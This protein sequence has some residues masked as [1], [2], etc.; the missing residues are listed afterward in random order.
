MSTTTGLPANIDDELLARAAALS[1]DFTSRAAQ[2]DRDASFPFENFDA[3]RDAGLL[4]LTI[5]IEFGGLSASLTTVC[6]V[7]EAIGGGDPSTALVLSMHYLGHATL[8]RERRWDPDIY[9]RMCHESVQG[10]ALLAPLRVEP[11]LGTPARGGLPETVATRCTDGWH[12]TGHKIYATGSP[13]VRYF[14]TWGRTADDPP[15]LGRFLVPRDAPGMRVVETWDH[16]GM[17]ASG[18]HD[19]LFEDALLPLEYAVDLR[20]PAAWAGGQD[21]STAGWNELVISSL[22]HGVAAAA[23]DWLVQYLNERV[24]SNLG[25]PLASLPRF[26]AAMG[27]IQALLYASERLIY[28][29]AADIDSGS[30]DSGRQA[31]IVKYHTTT[32]GIRAVDIMLSLTGNPGLMRRHPLE[33]YHRDI[34]CSRI[35]T[36]Q[37]DTILLNAGKAA[38]APPPQ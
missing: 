23:R 19:I 12:L 27:E 32:N 16:L 8:A 2:H 22:Y 17:R 25:A 5:P 7:I 24:P 30:G 6:R 34:L 36:P 14:N 3:L 18:S 13:I 37:D 38:L 21:R 33:R 9:E 35:H 1:A 11:E 15:L 29:C 31:P 26:Q 28:T 4:N 20:P 10:I